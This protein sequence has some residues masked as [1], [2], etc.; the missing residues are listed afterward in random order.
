MTVNPG[1]ALSNSTLNVLQVHCN[2]K[3]R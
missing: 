2:V 3:A 1:C